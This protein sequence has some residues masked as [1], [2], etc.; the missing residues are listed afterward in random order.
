[1]TAP[2]LTEALADEWIADGFTAEA[3]DTIREIRAALEGRDA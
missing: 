3:P 2:T 1:M